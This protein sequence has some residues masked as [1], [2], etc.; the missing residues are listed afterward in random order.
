VD[1]PSHNN[2]AREADGAAVE[3]F[4]EDT[5]Q[6]AARARP[7]PGTA[8]VGLRVQ[9]VTGRLCVFFSRTA[10]GGV[11][12]RGWHGGERLRGSPRQEASTSQPP[13]EKRIMTLFKEVPLQKLYFLS[14]VSLSFHYVGCS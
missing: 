11:D 13:T 10:D 4:A 3:G 2:A 9:P 6:A 1:R 8:A 7:R 12:P 5:A 14:F